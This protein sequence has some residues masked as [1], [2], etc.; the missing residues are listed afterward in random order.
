VRALARY[1]AGY[2]L[3]FFR[4]R[5]SAADFA[6]ERIARV[7]ITP[8][9]GDEGAAAMRQMFPGA[10]LRLLDSRSDLWRVR[11]AGCDVAC[12]GMMGGGLR[13]RAVTLLSGARH[14]L[15]VPSPDY[16][17]RLGMREGMSALLWACV[18]RF[19]LAPLALVWLGMLG[20]A[21]YATGLAG[22]A[23]GRRRG[24]WR[25]ERVLLIRLV[26]TD[27]FVHLLRRVR[28]RLPRARLVALLASAEGRAE[29]AAA[30]DEAISPRGGGLKQAARGGGF[31]SVI[32][33]GGADYGF[34]RTYLKAALLAR[35]AGGARRYQWEVGEELPGTP[36]G[37][38]VWRAV[39][40][41]RRGRGGREPGPLGRARLRRAYEREPRRGPTIAQ[42]GITKACNYHCLFCPFHSP[43]VEKGHK[44]AELPRMSYEM[45][46]R[47]LG[48]LKRMGTR[49]V[50][51]CGD[52]EPLTHPEALDMIALAR[53]LG[54]EVTL[55]TN[56]ALLTERRARRLVEIGV[57]RMH[58]S[59]NAATDGTY[60]QLHVGAPADARRRIVERLRAMREYAEAEGL[61]PID[62]EFSAVLNRLNMNEIPAM[63]EVAH[64]ARAG[65][66]MLILMGP[67]EG[68]EDLLPRPEDWVLIRA[69]LERAEARAR[70]LGMRT[71][72]E[73]VRMGA[74]AA[75]T[76]SVYERIPC[77]IG[78]EYVLIVADGSVMFCCQCARPLGNLNEDRFE[79]I[80]KSEVYREARRR[81]RALPA[82]QEALPEC[83][84]FDACSHVV[85]NV[86]VYRKLHGER[87][88]RS[89]L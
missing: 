7:L 10:E 34:G 77:Y 9:L 13:E 1:A 87:A 25:A 66:F 67:I 12:I 21:A 84:C 30:C 64:E 50:D 6:G 39:R 35:L 33:A 85:V 29:V 38:A 73:A 63:V 4:E 53:E 80:W 71:N 3:D 19:L 68:G 75:G 8:G 82:T 89:V 20:A 78:H 83:E 86:A 76:K 2:V 61:R 27:T 14:K 46:A 43:G 11:R 58:V 74:S 32:L 22:R 41:G 65:W 55:A 47:L 51:I 5:V 45:F 60:A 26:P 88:L 36:L 40:R 52:G 81:A 69:D 42:I 28:R 62:V 49:G 24:P 37:T 70:E 72:L 56:A 31:D 17:Y 23:A 15:L 16:A 18:D 59:F 48:D 79:Q 54:F 44:D 57:R